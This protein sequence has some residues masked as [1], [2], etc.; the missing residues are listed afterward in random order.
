MI[1]T[2]VNIIRNHNCHHCPCYCHHHNHPHQSTSILQPRWWSSISADGS[3]PLDAGVQIILPGS[4]DRSIMRT[5]RSTS[6]CPAWLAIYYHG[7]VTVERAFIQESLPHFRITLLGIQLQNKI[8][9]ILESTHTLECT[10]TWARAW[11]GI[12]P[13]LHLAWCRI[14]ANLE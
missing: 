10:S 14:V 2:I 3:Q 6:M 12:E 9:R 4:C 11:L 1:M 7:N 13:F 8:W 5:P